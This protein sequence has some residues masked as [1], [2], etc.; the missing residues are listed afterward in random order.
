MP[1]PVLPNSAS[2]GLSLIFI[3]HLHD[4]SSYITVDPAIALLMHACSVF[5]YKLQYNGTVE[6][7]VRVYR[8]DCPLSAH[9]LA[10]DQSHEVHACT[11]SLRSCP[12]DVRAPVYDPG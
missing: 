8:L 7:F 10:G 12:R 9:G 2:H 3:C 5:S 1:I 11:F 4:V 6:H